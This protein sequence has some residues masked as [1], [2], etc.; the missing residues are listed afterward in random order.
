MPWQIEPVASRVAWMTTDG[1]HETNCP[2][3][4]PGARAIAAGAR[5][6]ELSQ[7]QCADSSRPSA[8]YTIART[9]IRYHLAQRKLVRRRVRHPVRDALPHAAGNASARPRREL[10]AISA[11]RGRSSRRRASCP[12]PLLRSAGSALHGTPFLLVRSRWSSCRPSTTS[13]PARLNSPKLAECSPRSTVT[14]RRGS[15]SPG[16]GAWV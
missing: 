14:S 2:C 11:S 3:I 9:C 6:H 15:C 8:D 5:R 12:P 4:D 13:R 16:T 10:G 7:Q 1:N